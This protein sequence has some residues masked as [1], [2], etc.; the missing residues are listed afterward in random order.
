MAVLP[1]IM[2]ATS[3][4]ESEVQNRSFGQQEVYGR[5]YPCPA[6]LSSYG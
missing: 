1:A 5:L 2:Q 6:E 3:M 4:K